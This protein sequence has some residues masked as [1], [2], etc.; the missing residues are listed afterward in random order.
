MFKLC[1]SKAFTLDVGTS[2]L[3]FGGML[4]FATDIITQIRDSVSRGKCA[5]FSTEQN[6]GVAY[7]EGSRANIEN[8]LHFRVPTPHALYIYGDKKDMRQGT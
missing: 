5:I 2:K 3:Y 7:F 6:Y 8:I 4:N 1:H